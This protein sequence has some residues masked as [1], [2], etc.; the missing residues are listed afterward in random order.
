MWKDAWFGLG[1]LARSM[2][3]KTP[4]AVFHFFSSYI[5]TQAEFELV[6]FERNLSDCGCWIHAAD[7]ARDT[8]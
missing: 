4:G 8:K 6:C 3:N 7:S 2:K 1:A 5:K